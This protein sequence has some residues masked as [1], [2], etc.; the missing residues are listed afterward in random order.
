MLWRNALY[1]RRR[2]AARKGKG[3]DPRLPALWFVTDPER[4]ADPVA[5]AERLPPG[6]GVIYRAF[7]RPDAVAMGL[8]LAEVARRRGLV[9]LVGLDAGLA[10]KIGAAGVH[11]PERA[12]HLAPRLRQRQPGWLITGAAHG[13]DALARGARFGLDAA[14]V[15]PVFDSRSPSAG[16]ALGATR[17]ARLVR[18]SPLPVYALGGVAAGTVQRLRQSGAVGA[19]SV[20]GAGEMLA[21]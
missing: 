10:A 8:V 12:L 17:F 20:A 1:L 18:G 7:G 3:V 2:A 19:A 21:Q 11:L 6:A 4:I 13:P 5:V 14:L 16:R 9:L 15:S